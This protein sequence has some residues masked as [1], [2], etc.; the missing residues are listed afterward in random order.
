MHSIR[1]FFLLSAFIVVFFGSTQASLAA[2]LALV[3]G[4]DKYTTITPLHKA[5]SDARALADLLEEAG[6]SV[7]KLE[8]ASYREMVKAVDRFSRDIQPDD[9]AVFFFAGHGVQLKTGNYIL[10]ID[11]DAENESMVQ[12][13]SYS[14]DDIT[15]LTGRH[16]SGFQLIII[17]ACRDNP[18]PQRTRS[19]GNTRGLIPVE[20]VKG[21][22]VMYSASRGQQA[23]DRLGPDDPDENG[24]FTRNLV[25]ELRTPGLSALEVIRNVQDDVEELANSV[26][27]EQRPAVYNESRGNFYFFGPPKN[28]PDALEQEKEFWTDAR[29]I[30]N[31]AALEAYIKSYPNGRYV[32][33]ARAKVSQL[34]VT[35]IPESRSEKNELKEEMKYWDEVR[36]KDTPDAYEDYLSRYPSGFFIS[37][38]SDSLALLDQELMLTTIQKYA[39]AQETEQIQNDKMVLAMTKQKIDKEN[40]AR[41]KLAEKLAR[42]DVPTF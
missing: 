42:L 29:D 23:L 41:V 28:K 14:L 34:R 22:M 37:V 10:P 6:F 36:R 30:G 11:V 35:D 15:Y 9:Q 26:G 1:S 40:D 33:L 27:H 38:A 7:V 39:S 18:F 31:L 3:I 24:I 12:M 5:V 32:S 25:S 13:T 8:N 4:N 19:F 2:K 17:D 21:Q 16:K 20:P